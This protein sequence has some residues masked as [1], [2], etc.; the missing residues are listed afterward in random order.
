[1]ADEED[2]QIARE[3][4]ELRVQIAYARAAL[5]DREKQHRDAR[6]QYS[7]D[8][9]AAHREE[10]LEYQ[11]KYREK[12]RAEDP[13]AFREA[14]RQ[15]SK[16]WRDTHREEFRASKRAKYREDPEKHRELQRAFYA[17]N[18]EKIRARRR[19]YYAQNKEKQNARQRVWREREKRRRKAG[20]P[21]RRVR[22]VPRDERVANRAA[23]D[24][25]FAR[26]WTKQELAQARKSIATPPELFAAWKRDC[27]RARA[28]FHL[29]A[30]KEELE[31]LQKELG[32]K[33]PGPK[34]KPRPTPEQLAEARL[35]AIGRA[36]NDRLRHRERPRRTHHLDP[37][38]PH[39]MLQPNNPMGM[40]R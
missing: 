28:A 29:A 12:K 37:A 15:A 17:A 4:E 23:A 32:R 24:E 40:N 6:R 31:R 9:Y 39:P 21:P 36:V 8:Y 33:K 34:P 2:E 13:D 11:R 16:R 10:Y 5:N 30:Q 35:D 22:R 26:T 20:L 19:E 38:A 14:K 25:F 18:A 3:S 1:M 27:L 7:R